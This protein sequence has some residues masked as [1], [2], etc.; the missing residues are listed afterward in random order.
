MIKIKVEEQE[1][2]QKISE[3]MKGKIKPRHV[4]DKIALA[5][6]GKKRTEEQNEKNRQRAIKQFSIP[7]N[8]E[9]AKK[10]AI[11]QWQNS[12]KRE[13]W[14]RQIREKSGNEIIRSKIK[15]AVKKLWDSQEYR[16]RMIEAHKG[17]KAWNKGVSMT[18]GYRANMIAAVNRPNVLEIKR[19][20]SKELWL[21]P[22]YIKKIQ[23][24]YHNKPNKP[25]TLLFRLLE[26]LHP[27]EW[28]YTGDFS[29][30]INGKC[31]DF[32]N[33]NGEKKI[34]ELFGDYWHRGED[35]QD[36][37]N[38]FSNFGYET[39][40]IWERELKNMDDLKNKIQAFQGKET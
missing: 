3:A 25:E 31:P 1:R 30:I 7:D 5:L 14:I 4:V 32:V 10:A 17:Q 38:D 36:R 26:K 18:D 21:K 33:I 19:R 27:G 2:R 16:A 39:L 11:A 22:D 20:K 37:I 35:P 29:F 13:K 40:V 8:R 23:A 24:A 34:I 9:R 15:D 6:R 12:E 28:K